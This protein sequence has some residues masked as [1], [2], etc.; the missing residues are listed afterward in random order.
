[1]FA[2]LLIGSDLMSVWL[3]GE[4]PY[5]LEEVVEDNMGRLSLDEIERMVGDLETVGLHVVCLGRGGIMTVKVA[6]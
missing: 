1:M 6:E 5:D 3:D 2:S 4:G